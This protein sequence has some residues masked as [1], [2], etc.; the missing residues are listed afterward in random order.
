METTIRMLGLTFLVVTPCAMTSWASRDWACPTRF[1]VSVL[2]VSRSVPTSK[3]TLSCM[4]PSPE[5]SDFMYS[6][7]STPLIC[8][9]MGV[10]TDCS[11]TSALAPG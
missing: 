7:W 2:A 9:S 5:L 11:T 8:C 10:A 6:M 3:V 1:W 4:R